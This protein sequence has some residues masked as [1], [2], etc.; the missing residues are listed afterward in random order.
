MNQVLI[1]EA[2]KRPVVTR[3]ELQRSTAQVA[4]SLGRTTISCAL[5][6]AGVLWKSCR[7]NAL[8]ISPIFKFFRSN[9]GAVFFSRGAED[10]PTR[11][12]RLLV[13]CSHLNRGVV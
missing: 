13:N 3:E 4:E 7:K 8:I 1:R 11:F 5:H 12:N 2:A 6:K 10:A 9:E